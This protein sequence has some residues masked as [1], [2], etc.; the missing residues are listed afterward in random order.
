ME[1]APSD[2]HVLPRRRTST[3]PLEV[4]VG[5]AEMD[6]PRWRCFYHRPS[7]TSASFPVSLRSLIES[8]KF[9]RTR[10]LLLPASSPPP[11]AS[12]RRGPLRH[13]RGPAGGP[14]R[15]VAAPGPASSALWRPEPHPPGGTAPDRMMRVRP[16]GPLAGCAG[17]GLQGPPP[18]AD[19]APPQPVLYPTATGIIFSPA[20]WVL[21]QCRM[22]WLVV[23][24]AKLPTRRQALQELLQEFPALG[25]AA[26]SCPG[27]GLLNSSRFR[28]L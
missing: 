28:H 6:A 11:S 22:K 16:R 9:W 17:G 8:L 26:C 20:E 3:P 1:P 14:A 5:G 15:R 7:R 18:L 21:P 24:E 23:G 2:G 4:E 10:F 25:T 27:A 12:R 19:R 13:L